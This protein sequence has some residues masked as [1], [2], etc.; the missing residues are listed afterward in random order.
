MWIICGSQFFCSCFLV[1]FLLLTGCM[2]LC[3]PF[4]CCFLF[5]LLYFLH[6]YLSLMA[7]Y[8][9]PSSQLIFCLFFVSSISLNLFFGF[10]FHLLFRFLIFTQTSFFFFHLLPSL[11]FV[12]FSFSF[13]FR[14][15]VNFSTPSLDSYSLRSSSTLSIAF[16]LSSYLLLISHPMFSSLLQPSLN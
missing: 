4:F 13:A 15:S 11:I 3:F 9:L 12:F 7:Y 16:V 14:L 6:T 1:S 2:F 5:F 10:I 8:F